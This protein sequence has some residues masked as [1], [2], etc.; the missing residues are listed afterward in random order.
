[1]EEKYLDYEGLITY[2]RNIKTL[3]SNYNIA[4]AE[5]LDELL[6]KINNIPINTK[7]SDFLNDIGFL[8]TF[9]GEFNTFEEV[10]NNVIN[11]NIDYKNENT[12]EN[13]D[14]II[15]TNSADYPTI[16]E[17]DNNNYFTFNIN[18]GN[19][20]WTYSNKSYSSQLSDEITYIGPNNDLSITLNNITVNTS[21]KIEDT[22]Y[23]SGDIISINSGT[24]ILSKY[25]SRYLFKYNGKWENDDKQGWK[26]LFAIGNPSSQMGGDTI[27]LSPGSNN[28]TLKLTING[29][30]SDN[31]SVT[32]LGN[33]A[34]K[35]NLTKEDIGLGN[36]TNDA[37]VKRSEI[38][39]AN[40]IATLNESGKIP[41]SQLP[42][43]MDDVIEG[44]LYENK[45]YKE[46]SH[47]T[48]I[49]GEAGKIYTDLATDRT[50][51]WGESTFVQI[52]G[53][54]VIGNTPGTAFDGYL[55]QSHIENEDIHVTAEEKEY[56]NSKVSIPSYSAPTART[57]IY[58]GNS[59]NLLNAG[60]CTS[61]TIQYSTDESS[62]SDV[63]PQGINADT[64][65]T[66]WR[67]I[68]GGFIYIDSTLIEV[69]IAKAN[70]IYS[71]PTVKN[72]IYNGEP[73]VLLNEGSTNHGTITYSLDKETWGNIPQGIDVKEYLIYWK[74]IGDSN[75][76]D[77]E[78]SVIA[79]IKKV[80]PTVIAPSAKTLVYNGSS[81]ELINTG[82][83]NFGTLQYSTDNQT[84]SDTIIPSA[85][86]SGNY[87]VY[88]RVLGDN[89]VNNVDS[90]SF[91]VFI[92]KADG[93]ISISERSLSY[94]R[95]SQ[96]LVTVSGNT[97]TVH[98]SLNNESWQ[99]VIPKAINA[100]SYVVYYYVDESANYKALGSSSSPLN[101]SINISKV[102]PIL[103][104]I[105]VKTNDWTYDGISYLLASGG[106]MKH[107]ASDSTEVS[108]DFEYNSAINAGVYT[109]TWAFTPTDT[110]NYN[111]TNGDLGIVTVSQANG[112]ISISGR[113][114]NYNGNSQNLVT[115]SGNTG[116]VHYKVDNGEWT[117]TIPS[118]TNAG[119]WT[120][121]WYM[122]SSTN[123]K[124]VNSSSNPG[125]VTGT[126]N[127]ISQSAP[128]ASGAT[129]VYP[130]TATATTSGGGGY[131]SIEWS[132]GNTQTSIGSKNT[133][134][135][136]TGN[137]NYN[138]SPWSNE[139]TL[140]MNKATI[141]IPT[142][143]NYSGT[144]NGSAH[145][146]TFGTCSGASITKYR[147]STN[148][149]SWTES[150][151]NP[152]L[153]NV[154]TLYSQAYYTAD[155]NH[156]GSGW[157][158]SA[159]ISISKA[160]Q[161]AP[162]ATGS[163]V[164]YGSTAI[165][166]ASGGGGKGS[167]EWSNGSS[168]TALGSQTTKA[169]WTGNSN[170]NASPWSNTVTLTVTNTHSGHT[171]VDLGLPS[172]TKW[173]ATNVGS[174]SETGYGNIYLYGK[175]SRVYN[176]DDD[177]YKGNEVPL[178]ISLDTARQVWGGSWHMPTREQFQELVDNTTYQ[179][180]TINNVK[181]G[182][183]TASN[184]NYI[185]L[186]AE[187]MTYYGTHEGEGEYG[188]YLSSTPYTDFGTSDCYFLFFD[189][190]RK[191]VHWTYR[192]LGE[193]V[194]PVIG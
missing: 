98:Y 164:S 17:F 134:A 93:N 5:A 138:A 49:L 125:S 50:Y 83:T 141:N 14:Y 68:E 126:I 29:V 132:N 80:T 88:W 4:I 128:T 63:I 87:T 9:R 159:T 150:S 61:G 34:F 59:Q 166:S 156:T 76:L 170:Y 73:Q 84:W 27:I 20:N 53:D 107:S 112:N 54:L 78:G 147:Y 158:S 82:S 136:W 2:H 161:S 190:T 92:D 135:R 106:S 30:V 188:Y 38:G 152:S 12:P 55:G 28:G 165:A 131:G 127:K 15:I 22:P 99:T 47:E 77:T 142:P 96:N 163:S 144:Y 16:S 48:E 6:T 185:F 25:S 109:A 103:S 7:L 32:G 177:T 172:G 70:P 122:D 175:G 191:E 75:H 89:N 108:G 51:R 180:T 41:S 154:G 31:I 168:R 100:G 121:Y 58:N 179:W 120:I 3:F 37:Q 21:I 102:T 139:V 130:T 60:S 151:S 167:I 1:M 10:P 169:R 189:S 62:W 105:P 148:N 33:L 162:T 79:S 74:L 182:K 145:Y 116:L 97:G 173:A 26:P 124:A 66:Y 149:S 153:T 192:Y 65:T 40:G 143:T 81:Q 67:F 137:N 133:K 111:S 194:R 42:S 119:S 193:P 184:G 155:S 104:I 101:I 44:Y 56:W 113:T 110:T 114:I 52:K 45:F 86:N 95:N 171:F 19:I 57:L 35:D 72:L 90:T 24:V 181:G 123:Y 39:V 94:N 11:Y 176:A 118:S 160:N 140:T 13:N 69:D 18:N 157:S 174:S 115:T 129:T 178:S 85:I 146:A 46:P 8:S 117:T 64:Y 183:F 36:V 186:P 23:K 71:A 43:Y 187:G 91:N